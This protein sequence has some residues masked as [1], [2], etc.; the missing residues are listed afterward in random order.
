LNFRFLFAYNSFDSGLSR[1]GCQEYFSAPPRNIFLQ[2][3]FYFMSTQPLSPLT[4][5]LQ[6]QIAINE[7]VVEFAY[8][9]MSERDSHR[10]D[11][12]FLAISHKCLL[13]S[14]AIRIL[15]N[16]GRV[17]DALC[18]TRVLIDTVVTA[19]HLWESTEQVT[20]DYL[21]YPKYTRW[22][23]YEI[24]RNVDPLLVEGVSEAEIDKMKG[25]HEQV[26]ARYEAKAGGSWTN[27]G[28][29]ERAKKIDAVADFALLRSL[30]NVAWRK[31]S[32][33]LGSNA[34]SLGPRLQEGGQLINIHR[35]VASGGEA[36]GVLSMANMAIF[37][38]AAL[39][40][41]RLGAPQAGE[42]KRLHSRWLEG[43]G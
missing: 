3:G 9:L 41:L 33:Y 21:D 12:V 4:G 6:H 5:D 15:C 19:G 8:S 29:F 18:L 38:L 35:A 25:D 20:E 28:V 11:F 16:E 14:G 2:K 13:S 32:P 40:D 27:D 43:S 26:H 24:M 31:T 30:L 39:L 34:D 22:L 42:W 1:R 36:A 10:K 7:Q 23:E 17:D 37:A